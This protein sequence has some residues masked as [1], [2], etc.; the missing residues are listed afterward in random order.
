MVAKLLHADE[1]RHDNANSHFRKFCER[2]QN[3]GNVHRAHYCDAHAPFCW[4]TS[5][6]V[7]TCEQHVQN[8]KCAV[9]VAAY[10]LL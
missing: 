2:A 7:K 5:K 8:I 4:I 3:L 1:E 6:T 10:C 9:Y